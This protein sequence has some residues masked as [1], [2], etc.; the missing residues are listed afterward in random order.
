M[1]SNQP[2]GPMG[3]GKGLRKGPKAKNPGRTLKRLF[4]L[5]V[6]AYPFHCIFVVL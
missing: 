3:R 1:S 4:D 2:K 5:V 6:R